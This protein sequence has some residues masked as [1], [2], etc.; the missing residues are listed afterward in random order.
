MTGAGYAALEAV[1][2]RPCSD[3]AVGPVPHRAS[4]ILATCRRSV[5]GNPIPAQ[6]LPARPASASSRETT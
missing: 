2:R 6:H 5:P 3:T 1:R 4:G